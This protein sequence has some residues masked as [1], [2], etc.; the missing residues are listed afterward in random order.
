[1]APWPRSSRRRASPRVSTSSSTRRWWESRSRIRGSSSSD[2]SAPASLRTPLST[3]GISTRSTCWGR[4]AQV[5]TACSSIRAGSGGH[6][7]ASSPEPWTRP[8]VSFWQGDE[9]VAAQGREDLALHVLDGRGG[10]SLEAKGEV[11]VRV[12]RPDQS[13]AMGKQD[14]RPVDVDGLVTRPELLRQLSHH[15]E[16][17]LVGTRGLQLRRVVQMGQAVEVSR[18]RHC[19]PRDQLEEL[20]RREN[21][22]VDAVP[23]LAEEQVPGHLA[24]EQDAILAHLALE[25]RVPRLPHDG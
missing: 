14:A 17:A 19:A 13:P 9:R 5:S 16:L 2:S 6:A 20:T 1:M 21:S 12:R 3:S 15:V 10:L 22:V 23:V 25:M 8:C 7:I 4:G 24:A 18:D 11:R